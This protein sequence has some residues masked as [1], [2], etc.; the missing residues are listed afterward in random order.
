MKKFS[1]MMM[2]LALVMGMTQC[3][4]EQPEQQLIDPEGEKM[5]ITLTLDNSDAKADVVPTGDIAYVNY[6]T[7]D[8]IWVAYKGKWLGKLSCTSASSGTYKFNGDLSIAT[9]T[10]TN[11]TID[12]NGTYSESIPLM[13]YFFGN[14]MPVA[15]STA[16]DN[17]EFVIDLS[18]QSGT[19]PVISYAPSVQTFST[20]T[21][22]Y[23][24]KYNSLKNQCALV[25]FTM[26]NIYGKG[27]AMSTANSLD[28]NS[29][30]IYTT[31]KPITIYGMKN[32]VKVDLS[33]TSTDPWAYLNAVTPVNTMDGSFEWSV[34]EG[35]NGAI[36]LYSPSATEEVVRYAIVAPGDYNTPQGDLDVEF[37]PSSDP[38]GF[39]GTYRI[40]GD[41]GAVTIANNAFYQ[42]AKLDLVWH[43][44]A[45]TVKSST[46]VETKVV[47]S[48]GNAQYKASDDKW[49]FAKHQYDYVGGRV[50]ATSTYKGVVVGDETDDT[51]TAFNYSNGTGLSGNQHIA[52]GYGWIDLFGWG[53]GH[54]PTEYGEGNS[55]YQTHTDWGANNFSNSGKPNSNTWWSTLS[56]K[57]W[58]W[59]LE[60]RMGSQTATENLIGLATVSNV[61]GMILLPDNWPTTGGVPTM[62]NGVTV[63]WTSSN[64]MTTIN[65]SA[66]TF[67]ESKWRKME[68]FGA[69]FLPAAGYRNG[70]NYHLSTGGASNQNFGRY[71]SSTW[72]NFTSC[73]YM[74]FGYGVILNNHVNPGLYMAGDNGNAAR[75]VHRLSGTSSFGDQTTE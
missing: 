67:D 3:K 36:Q 48:R 45:F 33:A 32:Q 70:D 2:A 68:E 9:S 42:N 14:K 59:L 54:N 6:K 28:Q 26:E 58:E 24:V 55:H 69:V 44:G 56:H 35:T 47:F 49:R 66:M 53:T 21:A 74:A 37:N 30:A 13:F 19:L 61:Q 64:N 46:G 62:P 34:K 8:E 41:D 38:Y 43:S 63:T 10:F 27:T 4:K 60:D 5:N 57:E 71:W 75:L 12:D 29:N 17:T 52:D 25:K 73:Y 16:T 23:T 72:S 65:W 1:V 7:G 18:D 20:T 40:A 11:G 39:Y 15:A 31:T 51:Q 50:W 22:D